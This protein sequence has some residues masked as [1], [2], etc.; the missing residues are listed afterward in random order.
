[1]DVNEN[2]SEGGARLSVLEARVL[3]CLIEK[4]ATTPDLYPLSLNSLVNACNQKSNRSPVMDLHEAEAEAAVTLLRDKHLVT[5][6]AGAGARSVKFRHKFGESYPMEKVAQAMVTELMLR[7]PQTVAGLRGNCER[8]TP[9]PDAIETEAVLTELASRMEPLTVKLPRQSGQKE[10]RWAQLLTGSAEEALEQAAVGGLQS[11]PASAVRAGPLKVEMEMV[12]PAAAEV[13]L[14]T[15]EA[16]V[17]ELRVEL[18]RL[19]D[20]LG[21]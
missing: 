6:F 4:E 21:E 5:V 7:G 11:G 15:L 17:A 9:M 18:A 14:A 8:I 10:A 19:R 13:R 1:M 12:L 20:A 16:Q 2:G 3:A